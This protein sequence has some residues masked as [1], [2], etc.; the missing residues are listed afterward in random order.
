MTQLLIEWKPI[1]RVNNVYYPYFLVLTELCK[2][3][4][5]CI[6]KLN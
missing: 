3:R 1:N 2:R 6:H 5:K 4:S